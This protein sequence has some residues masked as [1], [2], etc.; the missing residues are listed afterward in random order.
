M[1]AMIPLADEFR[2]VALEQLERCMT[3]VAGGRRGEQNCMPTV[4]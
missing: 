2:S 3:W 1:R 4:S